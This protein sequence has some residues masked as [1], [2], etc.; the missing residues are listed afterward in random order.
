MTKL[1]QL[2]RPN[3][4]NLTPYSSARDEFS[5]ENAVFLDANENPFGTL[6]RYPDPYQ[7]ELKYKLA[8][9]KNVSENQLFIGNGSDEIID[10]LF[11][12][13]CE[14]GRDKTMT[15]SPTYGMYEVSANI[16]NVELISLPL[17]DDF[18]I[19]EERT[20]LA[21]NDPLIKLLFI[22]SPNN[23]TGN[24]FNTEIIERILRKFRGIVLIDE[25]YIDF[26]EQPSWSQHIAEFPNLVV[27][28]TLS[29]AYGLAAARVGIAITNPEIV[30]YLN[31]L[32]PPYNVSSPNQKAALKCLENQA[33]IE[34]QIAIVKSE[35]S[36][37]IDQLSQLKMV[38]R[39]FHT[40]SNFVL[41]RV[42]DASAIYSFLAS[43]GVV[44]RNRTQIIEN[45]LRI[46]I[47][48]PEENTQ[49]IQLL[50]TYQ[51]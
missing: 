50:K 3:I 10:L 18:E 17:S 13:F 49:L 24:V 15:F 39:V 16:N 31:K 47:G 42:S 8:M 32:K 37:V 43:E 6:N 25:A 40:Q 26:A 35:R 34:R 33:E 19:N 12:I 22:C 2:I 7:R 30:S 20:R 46:T 23:P 28:Q 1:E 41:V 5:G 9:I 4:L 36:L 51:L 21:I 48:S 11:R 14:P 27:C 45:C 29:K 44:V 38:K